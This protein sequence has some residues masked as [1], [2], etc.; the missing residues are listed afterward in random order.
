[1]TGGWQTS[2]ESAYVQASRAREGTEWFLARDELGLEG[3]D[4][5]RVSE[6][7]GEDARQPSAHALPP[8]RRAGQPR[9]GT[10]LRASARPKPQPAARSRAE[11][12]P[13]RRPRPLSGPGTMSQRLQIVLPD[14][15]A[16]PAPGAGRRS[17]GEPIATLAA[18]ILRN[19]VALAAEDRQGHERSQ[20][21]PKPCREDGPTAPDGLSPTAAT[22]HGDRRYGA[23]SW[24]CTAAT[25][26]HLEHLKDGW[27]T[28]EAQTETLCALATWRAE[29][30]DHGRDP[31]E[32]LAFHQQL[33]RLSPTLCASWAAASAG[34]GS[35][36]RRHLSGT[37]EC[38]SSPRHRR[39]SRALRV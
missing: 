7:R 10:G 8:A 20:H 1:M 38:T 37:E 19:G 15:V 14:P 4:E 36:A 26:G 2:K 12:P 34:R 25:P 3:Q 6:A 29:I 23:R 17:A 21:P 24:R 33:G 31:R 11:H 18:Q 39:P 13:R 27:W 5:R 9:M 28:D 35:P 22:P 16:S 30:D 32:E